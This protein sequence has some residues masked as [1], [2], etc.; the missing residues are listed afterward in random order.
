LNGGGSRVDKVNMKGQFILFSALAAFL[1]FAAASAR[2]TDSHD[3]ARDEYAIIDGG[4]APNKRISLASHGEGEGG[5][6]NFHIWLMAEPAHRK[7]IASTISVRTTISTP[8][9]N[10]TT[11]NGRR[12]RAASRF[13]SAATVT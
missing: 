12:I 2:A 1:A 7:I 5:V 9:Q 11:R 8:V 13:T 4:L 3:Y 6:E 10:P